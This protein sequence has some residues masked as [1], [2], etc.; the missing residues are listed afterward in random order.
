MYFCTE[1][2]FSHWEGTFYYEDHKEF[3]GSKKDFFKPDPTID[4]GFIDFEEGD[5]K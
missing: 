3:E 1:C 5:E 4:D 2:G